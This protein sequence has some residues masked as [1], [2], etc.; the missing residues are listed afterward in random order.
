VKKITVLAGLALWQA[1]GQTQID[2]GRQSRNADFSNLPFSRPFRTG[3][4][5]PATCMTGE[6]FFLTTAVAG[7]N[8]YG[9]TVANTWTLQGSG[10]AGGAGTGVSLPLQ[11]TWST[12]T[13]LQ[14]GSN[15][16][17]GAPCNVRLGAV[18]YN[19]VT[20]ATVTVVSGSGLAYLYIDGSGNLTAGT[21]SPSTPLITCTGCQAVSP[22][23]QFPVDSL[24]LATWNATSGTWDP[25]GTDER[26]VLT[27]GR[28]ITAGA[29]I[30]L[31][32]SGD[33]VT[34]AAV[35]GTPEVS[36]SGSGS[37]TYNPLDMTEFDRTIVFGEYGYNTYAPYSPSASCVGIGASAGV[38][39]ETVGSTWLAPGNPC[40]LYY[41]GGAGGHPFV[42]F[43]SGSTPLAY[44][45]KAR[46]AAGSGSTSAPSNVYVGWSSANDGTVNNFVGLRYLATA[47]V[48]QCV[49]RS[50]GTDLAASTMASMPDT[51]FHTF[52]VT[53][54][55]TPNTL[56]CQIDGSAQT[57]SAT[58]P[59]SNW[60]AVLG[61][62]GSPLTYF[63]A[64]EERIQILGISR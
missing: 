43:I 18:V 20:P 62:A 32:E 27:G 10:G 13:A 22:I 16:S 4:S 31:T 46:V 14:I 3:T 8:T 23:S 55:T 53:G 59:A 50:G 37:G 42:D 34:I 36:G 26:A 47:D 6:M 41:P 51:A 33:N 29:N 11:T 35:L 48:W 25:A 63:T 38:G 28:T 40:V 57:S 61:S 17:V 5:L 15:C 44:T 45:L 39:G 1:S 2:L 9:C 24:P 19:F 49:I 52:V 12:G 7:S 58:I 64:L 60:Y 21:S 30:Q 56:T 54:G